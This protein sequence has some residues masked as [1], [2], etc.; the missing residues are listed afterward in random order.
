MEEQGR[1]DLRTPGEMNCRYAISSKRGTTCESLKAPAV[2][3]NYRRSSRASIFSWGSF[4]IYS[5]DANARNNSISEDLLWL[6]R[7]CARRAGQIQP[8]I[9]RKGHYPEPGVP[10][11]DGNQEWPATFALYRNKRANAGRRQ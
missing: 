7:R 3:E 10:L 4:V 5:A 2:P 8:S 9:Y 11:G 6:E 1:R